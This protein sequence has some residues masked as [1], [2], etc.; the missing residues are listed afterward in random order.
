[1]LNNLRGD[2]AKIS[3]DGSLLHALARATGSN[4]RLLL[5][6]GDIVLGGQHD[7]NDGRLVGYLLFLSHSD[8]AFVMNTK[9]RGCFLLLS[10][11]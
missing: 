5:L 2:S 1:M 7:V 3:L 4:E 8:S 6:V 10:F 9:F 11:L